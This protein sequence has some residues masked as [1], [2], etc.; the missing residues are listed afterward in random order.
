M[1]LVEDEVHTFWHG[2]GAIEARVR[3]WREGRENPLVLVE[4]RGDRPVQPWAPRIATFVH[5]ALLRGRAADYCYVERS[6]AYD[7]ERWD[8]VDFQCCRHH[9]V[10]PTRRAITRAMV[11]DY[12]GSSV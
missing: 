4:A 5:N 11:E 3:V 1:F 2:I 6:G 10:H 12:V 7:D 9:L 8:L